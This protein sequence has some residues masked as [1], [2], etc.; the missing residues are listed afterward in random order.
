[1]NS[2]GRLTRPQSLLL[3]PT[4]KPPAISSPSHKLAIDPNRQLLQIHPLIK[5]IVNHIGHNAG[6]P[7]IVMLLHKIQP[8]RYDIVEDI[9]VCGVIAFAAGEQGCC[10]EEYQAEDEDVGLVEDLW[11]GDVF[12]FHAESDY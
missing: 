10:L 11:V 4:L 6:N 3:V 9:V 12:L 1:M 7:L 2:Q 5:I 8:F